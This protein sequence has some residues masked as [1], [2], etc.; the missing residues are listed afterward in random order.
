MNDQLLVI[1]SYPPKGQTHHKSVVGVASYAKNT[2]INLASVFEKNKKQKPSITVLAEKL[3]PPSFP[4]SPISPITYKDEG[5]TVKRLWQRNSFLTFP[6]LL[7]EVFFN[8]KE[9]KNIL[10][11]FELAM[12]G[13]KPFLLPLPLFVLLLRFL[14]KKVT[15]VFHQVVPDIRELHGHI[16]LNPNSF[17]SDLINLMLKLFYFLILKCVSKA[18]VFDEFLKENLSLF[19]SEDKITVIPHGVEEFN[20]LPSKK[21]SRKKLNI[22]NSHFVILSFG[23][24]AWYKGTDWLVRVFK[25]LK[26]TNKKESQKLTL[27]IAGGPNPNHLGKDYYEKY[28]ANIQNECKKNNILLTGF[29]P[30]EKIPTLFKAC[31]LVVFPYRTCMS[32]SGPLS[33]AFSFKKPFLVS[34]KLSEIFK[35]NDLNTLLKEEKINKEELIFTFN[36]K[37][38]DRI[39]K[40]REDK[41]FQKKVVSLSSKLAKIRSWEQIGCLYYDEIFTGKN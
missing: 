31:D 16:N 41:K 12:F 10:V 8:H 27:I 29:I 19:G 34:D 15:F 20:N 28:I 1:S 5:I 40:I 38:N 24:L 32:S 26:K 6:L 30:E 35:S 21:N 4:I 36:Q 2:L 37:I 18:I 33:L 13:E 22:P 25:H 17:Y 9:A 7:K 3:T 39:K 14:G 11:E 23:F